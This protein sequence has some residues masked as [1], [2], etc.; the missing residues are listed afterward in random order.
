MRV[1]VLPGQQD[2]SD[3]DLGDLQRELTAAMANLADAERSEDHA[4]SLT[5]NARN[6][7]NALQKRIDGVLAG[8]RQKA[9]RDS[10][11]APRRGV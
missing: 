3:G 4:R 9:P 11:W 6:Q 1:N 8:L 7:V 10:S 2:I 5:T